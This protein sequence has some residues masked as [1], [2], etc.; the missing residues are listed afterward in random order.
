METVAAMLVLRVVIVAVQHRRL[1]LPL[2][3][4]RH[5]HQHVGGVINLIQPLPGLLGIFGIIG[6]MH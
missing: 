1:S 6:E 5:H 4:L 3:Q 2:I